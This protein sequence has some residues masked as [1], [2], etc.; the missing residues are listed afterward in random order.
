MNNHQVWQKAR[1]G[2]RRATDV[3]RVRQAAM[4]IVYHRRS[5]TP[6]DE[7]S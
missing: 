1:G 7:N 5:A 3:F 2:G 6:M 4:T